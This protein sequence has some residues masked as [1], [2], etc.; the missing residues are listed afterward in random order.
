MD[1]SSQRTSDELRPYRERAPVNHASV[2]APAYTVLKEATQQ[3]MV[4]LK[5]I[6]T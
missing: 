6:A 5:L 2:G 3:T 1:P 4:S